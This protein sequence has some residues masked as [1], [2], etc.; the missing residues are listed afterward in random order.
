MAITMFQD[1]S[2]SR[3]ANARA[4]DRYNDTAYLLNALVH[5]QA[6]DDAEPVLAD[7][8]CLSSVV[9][10]GRI[11]NL[12]RRVTQRI[13]AAETTSAVSDSAEALAR[14]LDAEMIDGI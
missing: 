8:A 11:V 4:R 10:S 14:S 2:A 9:G 3:D 1:S 6:W 5:V 7:L 12:L 13:K